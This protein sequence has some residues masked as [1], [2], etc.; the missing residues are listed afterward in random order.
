VLQR[1]EQESAGLE[2]ARAQVRNAGTQSGI[3]WKT[4]LATTAPNCSS[5][6]AA[7]ASLHVA[8]ALRMI[9]LTGGR[10][11]VGA[12]AGSMVT[13]RRC[14]PTFPHRT[15]PHERMAEQYSSTWPKKPRSGLAERG[16]PRPHDHL[17]THRR[18]S[19]RQRPELVREMG[20]ITASAPR[21]RGVPAR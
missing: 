9:T 11:L 19:H 20:L 5:K 17:G 2:R 6:P 4:T 13:S 8:D 7:S 14:R 12:C 15:V 21:V 18:L 3:A 1:E 10:V 16:R